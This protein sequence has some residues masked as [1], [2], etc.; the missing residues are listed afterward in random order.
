MAN[1]AAPAPY[2]FNIFNTAKVTPR[3]VELVP[4]LGALA[5]QSDFSADGKTVLFLDEMCDEQLVRGLPLKAVLLPRVTGRAEPRLVPTLPNT[6]LGALAI[7]TLLQL[8]GAGNETLNGLSE[9]TNALPCYMLEL[10][11]AL[12]VPRVI[13]ELL[14]QS[15]DAS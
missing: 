7:S 11:D 14:E 4:A 1:A 9:L 8:A 10:G 5:A 15:R 3:S 12:A 13:E 2:A 6:A